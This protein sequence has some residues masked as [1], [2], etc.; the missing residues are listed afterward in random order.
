[1]PLRSR[2]RTV[3]TVELWKSSGGPN[4]HGPTHTED[5]HTENAKECCRI[6]DLARRI[7]EDAKEHRFS[8]LVRRMH[9][10]AT[11]EYCIAHL[12]TKCADAGSEE[13]FRLLATVGAWDAA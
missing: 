2:A 6:S 1:M 9:E 3:H 11:A 12:V 13:N 8:D 5:A 7:F 4:E 10:D